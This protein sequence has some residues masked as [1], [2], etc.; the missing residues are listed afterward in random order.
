[1]L[2]VNWRRRKGRFHKLTVNTEDKC[3][4][5]VIF[6][7]GCMVRKQSG[8]METQKTV[9]ILIGWGVWWRRYQI[10]VR[11]IACFLVLLVGS[12]QR[13]LTK[14][15]LR[16]ITMSLIVNASSKIAN[17]SLNC[18]YVLWITVLL[19][20]ANTTPYYAF[21]PKRTESQDYDTGTC[22]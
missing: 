4:D 3:I 5:R 21:H 22:K 2:T 9:P 12:S 11:N 8:E 1:M 7:L 18:K 17:F 19:I 20:I 15:Q 14:L 10:S 16:T 13:K 6:L